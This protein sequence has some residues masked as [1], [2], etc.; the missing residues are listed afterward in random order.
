[1]LDIAQT[2]K[3]DYAVD[4]TRV[5]MME[6]D[7]SNFVMFTVGDVYTGYISLSKLVLY[8]RY[9]FTKGDSWVEVWPHDTHVPDAS[10]LA[11]AKK[12]AY[13]FVMDSASFPDAMN[14]AIQRAV[15]SQLARDG[16]EHVQ[17]F[18]CEANQSH[19][20]TY[21]GDWL[22]RCIAFL[23]ESQKQASG[24]KP[25]VVATSAPATRPAEAQQAEAKQ[26][27]SEPDRLIRLA[28]MYLQAGEPDSATDKL[29]EVIQNYPNDPDADTARQMLA[30]ISQNHGGN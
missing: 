9:R 20:A 13:A 26:T 7:E 14:Y 8:E 19:Y 29:N 11:L 30:Q 18:N 5:Y 12:R 10:I 21:S 16:Y 24:E 1:L 27:D 3:A 28:K 17:I 25:V 22:K 23:D 15:P 4:K 2:M 6:G